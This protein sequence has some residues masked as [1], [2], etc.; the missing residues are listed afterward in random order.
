MV[1]KIL[2]G[3]VICLAIFLGYVSSKDG[4]FS[5]ER[6]DL[7]KAPAEKIFPLISTFEACKAWNP[8]DQKDPNMKR[9]IKGT[10]GQVGSIME[11]EGNSEAGSGSLEIVNMVPNESMT[12]TLRM[13]KP[14]K[15]ENKLVYRLTPE[16]TGTRFSWQMSGDGGFMSKLMSTLIDCEKMVTKDFIV[17]IENLKKLAEKQEM[18]VK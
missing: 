14:F 2:A 9:T 8:Y 5:Y 3:S 15:A 4:H 17:G 13:S 12:L 10:D 7:I 6:S 1:L 11:F 18:K 16:G